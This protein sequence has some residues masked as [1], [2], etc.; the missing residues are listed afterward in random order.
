M[1]LQEVA[2]LQDESGHWYVVPKELESE[3]DRLYEEGEAGENEF[4]EKFGQYA[5]GCLSTVKLFAYLDQ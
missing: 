3:F 5:T 4:I 1:N 2:V